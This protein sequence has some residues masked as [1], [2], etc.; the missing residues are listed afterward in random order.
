MVNVSIT[1][2]TDPEQIR[3]ELLRVLRNQGIRPVQDGWKISGSTRGPCGEATVELEVV[4]IENLQ[5]VGV[6]R[7]RLSGDAFIYKKIC[8]EVLRLA[9]L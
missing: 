1:S 2:S 7:K 3:T 5:Y 4:L 9:G 8:E 6:K